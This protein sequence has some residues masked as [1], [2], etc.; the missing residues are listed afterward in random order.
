MTARRDVVLRPEQTADARA[1]SEQR[2]VIAVHDLAAQRLDVVA[3]VARGDGEL[4]DR[5]LRER[6]GRRPA[7]VDI[8]R[9]GERRVWKIGLVLIHLDDAV[10]RGDR[11]AT[12]ENRIDETEHGRVGADAK[13]EREERD[14]G[15]TGTFA[16]ATERD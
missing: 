12:Q 14:D 11:G 2:E 8:V 1:E 6:S 16:S 13:G 10:G 3:Q 7:E 9:I 5:E 4:R 15:E